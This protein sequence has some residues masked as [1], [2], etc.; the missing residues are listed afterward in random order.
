[1]GHPVL[2]RGLKLVGGLF[3]SF[4]KVF[5][6]VQQGSVSL[7]SGRLRSTFC[8]L[9]AAE[10]SPIAVVRVVSVRSGWV[11]GIPVCLS[12]SK[13][14][15]VSFSRGSSSHWR[16]LVPLGGLYPVS[17]SSSSLHGFRLPD[18]LPHG[19]LCVTLPMSGVRGHTVA[20][21]RGDWCALCCR[22]EFVYLR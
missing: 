7:S 1:L 20:G 2:T 9:V 5:F 15:S 18:L 6:N 14:R 19:A 8:G 22:V 21:M 4:S 16:E 12:I 17:T 11:W 10:R 13:F 3:L